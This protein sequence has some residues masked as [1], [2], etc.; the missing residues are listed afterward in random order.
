MA[1]AIR[2]IY[3]RYGK[4]CALVKAVGALC[5]SNVKSMRVLTMT[6]ALCGLVAMPGLTMA[7]TF[8]V[9]ADRDSTLD[10]N[11]PTALNGSDTKL[12]V[13]AN[14][15]GVRRKTAIYGFTLPTIPPTETMVSATLV[16]RVERNSP[17]TISLHRVTDSWT[18]STVNWT[19]TGL[20]FATPAET[21]FT[22]PTDNVF[23]SVSITSL[24]R[25]WYNGT[26]ANNGLVLIS[27]AGSDFQFTAREWSTVRE[28][29]MLTI[30]TVINP[31]ISGQLTSTPISDLVNATI[32]PKRIPNAIVQYALQISNSANGS[33][34]INSTSVTMAIP[35]TMR[36]FVGDLA[37]VGSGPVIFT[38]GSPSSGL[39]YS[40]ISLASTADS[41]SF[42]NNN[43]T[44]FTYTPTPDASGFDSAVTQIRVSPTGIF[45]PKT[46]GS[47]PGFLLAMRMQVN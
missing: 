35:A 39:S 44:S 15:A 32:N 29:P 42:S 38:D 21:S 27:V 46:G 11:S 26:S 24:V 6:L 1:Q 5:C 4:V 41:L 23:V 37:A 43:G 7:A 28:R 30:T 40:F 12:S 2:S 22:A 18:E 45:A 9:T 34:D 8:T 33:A 14:N 3:D 31:I 36:L 20:D 16:L 10:E 17:E 47:N 19:N 13:F 25:Q